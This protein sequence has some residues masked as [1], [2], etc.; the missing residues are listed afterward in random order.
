MEKEIEEL[1][2]VC[3]QIVRESTFDDDSETMIVSCGSFDLMKRIHE[4]IILAQARAARKA[5]KS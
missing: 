5:V 1:I 2:E 3:G 4:S